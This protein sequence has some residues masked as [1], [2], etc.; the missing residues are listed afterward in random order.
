[1]SHTPPSASQRP[2]SPGT[3]RNQHPTK[4][5]GESDSLSPS[6]EAWPCLCMDFR[7]HIQEP[8]G[9][10]HMPCHLHRIY[11]THC[12]IHL[13]EHPR[14]PVSQ[15]LPGPTKTYVLGTG[16]GGCG[17]VVCSS[18]SCGCLGL[19]ILSSKSDL[20]RERL[21][22]PGSAVEHLYWRADHRG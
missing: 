4:H 11:R 1:M 22:H 17:H 8:Q 15:I 12:C 20:W 13:D 2:A 5:A 21:A 16:D 10:Y 18:R 14:Q 7:I 19:L 9:S 6:A 3:S